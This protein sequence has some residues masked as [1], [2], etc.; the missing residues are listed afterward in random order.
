M[1]G[2]KFFRVTV[3][4]IGSKQSCKSKHVE[5]TYNSE[6]NFASTMNTKRKRSWLSETWNNLTTLYNNFLESYVN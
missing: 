1:R 2:I 5:A 3:S 6:D 4:T